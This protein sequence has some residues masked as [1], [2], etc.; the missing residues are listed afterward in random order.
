MTEYRL[1]GVD[2]MEAT[3]LRRKLE[4]PWSFEKSNRAKPV[5]AEIAKTCDVGLTPTEPRWEHG[6]YPLYY[7]YRR[8]PGDTLNVVCS[9]ILQDYNELYAEIK[10][11]HPRDELT[12]LA[13]DIA[14]TEVDLLIEDVDY[15]VF[16]EAKD[17]PDGKLPRFQMRRGL[18]QLTLIYAQGLF[19]ARK[20]NKR[21]VLATLG[22][23][24]TSYSLR[25]A[26]K[27]LLACLGDTSDGLTFC[28]LSW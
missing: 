3:K 14:N 12:T 20:I 8:D 17:P 22:T 4:E 10:D 28:D 16:V 24:I 2:Q 7:M 5:I 11:D 15:F 6:V 13:A 27:K 25:E 23:G 21:F 18:H 26:D 19:L 9:R 1:V